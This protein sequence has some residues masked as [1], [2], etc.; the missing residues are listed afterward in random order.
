MPS[1]RPAA[2]PQIC[3]LPFRPL[4]SAGLVVLLASTCTV[5][6]ATDSPVGEAR[7]VTNVGPLTPGNVTNTSPARARGPAELVVKFQSS[8]LHA[9]NEC[10]ETWLRL[11]RSFATATADRDGSLDRGLRA[12]GVRE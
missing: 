3:A 7:P 2:F 4:W 1:R 11:G 5:P 12:W 6:R 9:V 8:G 10:A